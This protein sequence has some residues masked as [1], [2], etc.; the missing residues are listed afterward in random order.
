MI[1]HP[2]RPQLVAWPLLDES[3]PPVQAPERREVAR[4]AAPLTEALLQL[5]AD[6]SRASI[7]A[8]SAL[9]LQRP[10]VCLLYTSPS[11]RD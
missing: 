3:A 5:R 11:P 9:A 10:V 6:G 4:V 1:G 2:M 8:V 7:A